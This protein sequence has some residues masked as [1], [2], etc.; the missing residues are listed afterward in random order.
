MEFNFANEIDSVDKIPEQFRPLYAQDDAR[1]LMVLRDDPAVKGAVTAITGLNRALSASRAE[2]K[3]AKG[4]AIDL[5]PLSEFGDNPNS[6]LEGFNS[7]I[8][9]LQSE[10]AKGDKAKLNLDK[11][12][13]ELAEAHSKDLKTKDTRIEALTGQLYNLLVENTASSA[14]TE[15]KGVP[16]LLMPFIK[17]QVKVVEQDGEQKVFVTDKSGDIRYSGVTGQPMTIKE[18][19]SE[20]KADAQFGR[21]FES[22]TQRGGTGDN[23]NVRH[24]SNPRVSNADEM[25]PTDKIRSGLRKQQFSRAK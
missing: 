15:L 9:E 7:K 17:Q 4:R 10:L 2:A 11:I 18:L 8:T 1:S 5:T 25:S 21:L 6:I 3:A 14:V 20:M 13:Q 16:Q 24:S 19:V 12:K 23:Q 22:D